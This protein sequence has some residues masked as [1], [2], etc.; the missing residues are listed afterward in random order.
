MGAYAPA[1]IGLDGDDLC[2]VFINPVIDHLARGRHTVRRR[3]VR[4]PDADRR[5]AAS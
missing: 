3:A 1:P 4:R 2:K 5:R